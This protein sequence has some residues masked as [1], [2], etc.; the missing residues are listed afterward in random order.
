MVPERF[1]LCSFAFRCSF[2]SDLRRIP[3]GP[4]ETLALGACSEPIK[5]YTRSI[6]A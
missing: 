1:A 6:H 2:G 4:C 3:A 5:A